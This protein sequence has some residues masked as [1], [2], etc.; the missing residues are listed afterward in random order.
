[1]LTVLLHVCKIP[2][3]VLLPNWLDGG[4]CCDLG[5]KE[6]LQHTSNNLIISDVERRPGQ[7][8]IAL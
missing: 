8:I 2:N 5:H 4:G 6:R 7:S 1:M 3:H